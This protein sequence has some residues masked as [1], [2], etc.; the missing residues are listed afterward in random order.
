MKTHTQLD[1]LRAYFSDSK[2]WE[3]EIISNAIQSK[4]RAWLLCL[5]C[6]TLSILCLLALISVLPLKTFSPYIITVDK[7]TGYLEVTKGLYESN[8]SEDEA[9]TQANLVKYIT[10]RESY[11]PYVLRENYEK[12]SLMSTGQALTEY[13]ELWHGK[14][15][16]NPSI[17]LG[18]HASID[19]KIQGISFLNDRTV[20]LRFQRHLQQNN[21]TKISNWTA[22]IVFQYTQKPM[23]MADRFLNP[24][25]FQVI[26]YRINP[27]S[28]EAKQ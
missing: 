6:M 7:H 15:P 4:N 12:V 28:M 19:I 2:T 3:D 27:E 26:S 11:N 21:Q 13:Q 9:I 5:F 22:I 18:A 10:L 1:P 8:L 20:A 24:L 16:N 14:N 17:T 25:G 23:R